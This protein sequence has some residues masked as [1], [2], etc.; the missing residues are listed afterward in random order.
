MTTEHTAANDI[1][2]FKKIISNQKVL[3][4]D[5]QNGTKKK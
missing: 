4:T 5:I 2:S 3:L 1:Q